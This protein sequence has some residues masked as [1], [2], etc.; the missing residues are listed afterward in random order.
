[1]LSL[2]LQ[3]TIA[4][5]QLL[6]HEVSKDN[7]CKVSLLLESDMQLGLC[8][9]EEVGAI[10]LFRRSLNTRLFRKVPLCSYLAVLQIEK[11]FP[12]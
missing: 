7:F 12:I 1:M 11:A 5:I 4:I 8:W 2:L 6:K 10:E 9:I 3:P